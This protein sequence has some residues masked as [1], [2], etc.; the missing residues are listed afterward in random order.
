MRLS[1]AVVSICLGVNVSKAQSLDQELIDRIRSSV[2]CVSVVSE[3]LSKEKE[4]VVVDNVIATAIV[5]DYTANDVLILTNYH[6]WDDDEFRY[7]FPPPD[8]KNKGTKRKNDEDEEIDPVKLRLSNE[9]EFEYEFVLTADMFQSFGKDEDFAVLKLPKSSFKMQRIPVSFDISLTLKIHAFGYIGHTKAFNVTPG[10]VTG[11]VPYGFTMSPLSAEGFSGA[12]LVADSKGRAVG[13]MGGNL[14]ASKDKNS[15]H[16][17]Y[18]LRFD[19][20][21]VATK[22]Q[23]TPTYSPGL[24]LTKNVPG[25]VMSKPPSIKKC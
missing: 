18:G 20:V 17:S 7:C 22:R 3:E 8:K 12:A 4:K 16:Q 15:Q 1:Y 5:W 6:T 14:D 24:V 25:T 2:L 21:I 23:V 11:M 13:Y 10:E 19:K 9:D